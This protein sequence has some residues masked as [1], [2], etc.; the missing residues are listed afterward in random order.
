MPM[1]ASNTEGGKAIAQAALV[2]LVYQGHQNTATG[3][4]DGM[5]QGD[6]A[7]INVDDAHPILKPQL[8]DTADGLG[9]KSLVELD[10]LY[11]IQPQAGPSPAAF[12][13]AGT[14][15]SPM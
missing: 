3:G 10:E 5:P 7:A 14:G 13:V 1:P 12:W 15:P 4:A 11:V 2:H 8:P 9:G 6:G